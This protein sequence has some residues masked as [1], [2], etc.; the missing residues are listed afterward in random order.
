MMN[1]L[2]DKLKNER[3]E[4]YHPQWMA[5]HGIPP[6]PLWILGWFFDLTDLFQGRGRR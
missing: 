6:V 3:G 5:M 4:Y 2:M 1:K